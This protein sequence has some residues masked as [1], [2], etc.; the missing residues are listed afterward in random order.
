MKL[1]KIRLAI[2]ISNVGTG[3][4]LQAIIEAIESKKINAKIAVVV[5]DSRDAYGLVRARK[6]HLPTAINRKKA[7]LLALLQKYQV[8]FVCLAGWKQIITDGVLE[9]YPKKILNLHPGLI[10]DSLDGTVKNPDGTKALWNRSKLTEVAIKSFLDS[11]ATY[12][13]SSI[14]FLT[15]E[16]DFGPVCKRCFEKILAGDTVETLYSRLKLKEHKIYVKSLVKLC[17]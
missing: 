3:T 4:N 9:A 11:K 14:H 10:P 1:S 17:N 12:A 8:D 15:K 6:H 2:L 16:F 13:G 7:D 5:S